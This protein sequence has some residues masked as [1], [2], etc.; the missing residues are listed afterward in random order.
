MESFFVIAL[1][2]LPFIF[3]IVFIAISIK[4]REKKSRIPFDYANMARVPAFTL[5]QQH[6]DSTVD[7]L[8]YSLLA[9][10]YFQLPFSIPTIADLVGFESF[11]VSL[12]I[13]ITI[14][15]IAAMYSIFRAIKAANIIRTS[16]L[17]IEAEWAVSHALSKI[18]DPKVRVFHDVQATN[19]N[20]DHVLT[21]PGGV[22]AIETK[23]RR[24]PNIKNSKTTYKLT[25]EGNKIRF[26]KYIDT[27][28]IE[29]AKRQA[30]WLSKYLTKSTGMNVTTNPLVAIPGWYIEYKQK[31]IVPV[32]NHNSLPKHYRISNKPLLDD[33]SLERINH[34]LEAL[35][36]RGTD[37]F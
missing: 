6:K 26:P 31:P 20:I 2:F 32:M 36:L 29:Q 16:R 34:Q 3:V 9:T 10:L 4:L 11:K 23:G 13:L 24:K 17:G 37:L 1:S 22:I 25:V 14:F 7:L 5:L 35:T 18:A 15:F 33:S 30:D 12:P 21:Y 8:V 19:F 28:S 27:D